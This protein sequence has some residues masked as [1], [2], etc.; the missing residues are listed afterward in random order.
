MKTILKNCRFIIT[1][2]PKREILENK[3]I[4]IENNQIKKIGKNL[5]GVKTINASQRIVMPGLINL[6]TH[7][8]MQFMRGF[9]DDMKLKDWLE[10][11]IWP[12]EKKLTAKKVYSATKAACKE[13]LRTGTTCFNDMYFFMEDAAKAAEESG[14]RAFLSYGIID[15]GDR[16]KAKKELQ[17]TEK[18]RQF[19]QQQNNSQINFAY[20]PHSA[21]T[22]S[23]ET[24]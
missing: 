21:Y 19:L 12:E 11:K 9:A 23:R 7:A 1:Q 13:M 16:E 3:D 20:G 6:H 24:L 5:K 14:I 15:L 18:L 10:K 22:C 8:G 4:L 17:A 2:N